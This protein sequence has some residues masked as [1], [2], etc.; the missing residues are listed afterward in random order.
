MY[1]FY[2]QLLHCWQN[3]VK[4]LVARHICFT[5]EIISI[6]ELTETTLPDNSPSHLETIVRSLYIELWFVTA[7]SSLVSL[8][9]A[10][11]VTYWTKFEPSRLGHRGGGS[12]VTKIAPQVMYRSS[13]FRRFRANYEIISVA[14]FAHTPFYGFLNAV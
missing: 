6:C 10:R 2:R 4:W 9:T 14:D 1:S 8:V 13:S 11:Q 12:R 7:V 3:L 5:Y